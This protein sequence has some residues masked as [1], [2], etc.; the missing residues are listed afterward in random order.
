MIDTCQN[1]DDISDEEFIAYLLSIGLAE[2][3]VDEDGK[4]RYAV[5]D[6]PSPVT[7]EEVE[8]ICEDLVEQG[9]LKRFINERGQVAYIHIRFV[10]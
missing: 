4:V 9:E 8:K 1:N 5:F 7:R 6:E 10:E 3:F 2:P